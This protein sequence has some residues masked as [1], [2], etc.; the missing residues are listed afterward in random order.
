LVLKIFD[1]Q[2]GALALKTTNN[3]FNRFGPQPSA[4]D[5]TG[6]G[7][8]TGVRSQRTCGGISKLAL[9]RSEIEKAPGSLDQ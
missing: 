4:M 9:R 6:L 7:L 8:K 2:F 3:G 1:G 5:L